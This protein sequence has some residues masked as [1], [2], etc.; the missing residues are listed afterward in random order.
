METRA[1][2]NRRD[3]LFKTLF[4]QTFDEMD[5]DKYVGLFIEIMSVEGLSKSRN[6]YDITGTYFIIPVD[7]CGLEFNLYRVEGSGYYGLNPRYM[8]C[9]NVGLVAIDEIKEIFD[10]NGNLL[11]NYYKKNKELFLDKISYIKDKYNFKGLYY[12]TDFG[13]LYQILKDG[14]ISSDN[15][16]MVIIQSLII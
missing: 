13:R 4:G 14:Y 11:N 5:P 7:D 1:I 9:K 10:E 3:F 15:E 2:K 12:T 6:F 16:K 8:N